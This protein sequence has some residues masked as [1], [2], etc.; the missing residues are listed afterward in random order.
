[1]KKAGAR[2]EPVPKALGGHSPEFVSGGIV[3]CLDACE[4]VG[5]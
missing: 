1:M 2:I 3:V 4:E 5:I